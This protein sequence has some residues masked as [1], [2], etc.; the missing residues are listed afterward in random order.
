MLSGKRWET[1][2]VRELQM[3]VSG[4]KQRLS[5][6][7][8]PICQW[9]CHGGSFIVHKGKTRLEAATSEECI[10]VSHKRLIIP[11]SFIFS[12]V[13]FYS[14]FIIKLCRGHA[15]LQQNMSVHLTGSFSSC[16]SALTIALIYY[17]QVEFCWNILP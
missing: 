12:S 8:R 15:I 1:C 6:S 17:V 14:N 2:P 7:S 9:I 5:S 10:N 13:G 3:C 11:D 16:Y 4:D